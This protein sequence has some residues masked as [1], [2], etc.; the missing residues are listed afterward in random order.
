[1]KIKY[2]LTSFVCQQKRVMHGEDDVT[3]NLGKFIMN[4]V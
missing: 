1:M 4:K 2:L 3:K